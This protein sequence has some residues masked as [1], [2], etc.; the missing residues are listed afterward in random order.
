MPASS[1]PALAK[2]GRP[3]QHPAQDHEQH[4][5]GPRQ[6]GRARRRPR[7]SQNAADDERHAVQQAPDDEGEARAV[8]QPAQAHGDE[9][10]LEVGG[11]PFRLPPSGM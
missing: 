9:R 7:S 2:L 4:G 10:R 5:H 8:P 1:A 3:E 6:A 11:E